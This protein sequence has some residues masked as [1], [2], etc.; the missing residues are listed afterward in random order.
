MSG[1]SSEPIAIV[2]IGCRFPGGCDT[3]SKLW[4]L[5]V[6][7]ED[8][9]Q[10]IP[11]DRFNVDR[12][13]H[14][15]G[16]HHGTTNVRRAYML[17]EDISQFDHQFFSITP[18]QAAAIDPQQ[19]LLLEVT[20]EAIESMGCTME[21]LHGSD[22]AVFVGM[23]NND[24]LVQQALD[25]DFSP[26]YNATGVAN[27]NAS[28]RV[29]YFFDWHGPSMTLDTACSSSLVAVYEAVQAIR[30]GTSKVAVAAGANLALIPLAYI[31]TS[32]LSM[33]S[34]TGKSR[35]WDA[36]ADGYA[37]GE[38]VA[39]V[40]LKK[41]SDAI[42]DG[43]NIQGVIREVGVNHDGR[44]AGLTMP[45]AT[46]QADLIRRVYRQAGLDP[47]DRNDRCQFFEAHGTGT[48]AGDPQEAEALSKAFFD[49]ETSAD[50]DMLFVGSI[51]TI[52][53]HTESTAGLAGLLRACLALK[54]KMI[55]PNLLFKQLNPAVAPFTSHLRIPTSAQPWPS[56]HGNDVVRRA[57]V[58]S[59]GFGGANAHVI[60]ESYDSTTESTT[61][62]TTESTTEYATD[63]TTDSSHSITFPSS[64][65][66]SADSDMLSPSVPSIPFVFSA[67][68]AGSLKANLRA[69]DA[70]LEQNIDTL[71]SA[72]LAHNLVT[73]KMGF[74]NRV[75]FSAGSLRDLK[76]QILHTLEP[77]DGSSS[78]IPTTRFSDKPCILGVFTG[79]GAQWATMGTKL[80]TSIPIASS[81][82][83]EL[84]LALS[85]LPEEDRPAWSLMQELLATNTSRLNQAE[86]SQPLCTAVQLV[87]V[88]LLRAARVKFSAVVGHSSGEIA[89][90]YAAGFIN[91]RDAMRISF[92]RGHYA[93][94]ASGASGEPGAM[95]AI[96]TSIE[97]AQELCQ[98]E[99]FVETLRVAAHNSPES[100]TLSGDSS[101]I[102]RARLVF[103]E[104]KKF[105]RPLKVD[106]AYHSQHMKPCELPY[107]RALRACGVEVL[108]P[109]VEA[110]LWYSSVKD[111]ELMGASS[112]ISAEYWV[113]N[114]IQPVLFSRAVA[115]A[116]ESSG[117]KFTF[118]LEVGPH[119]ALKTPTLDTIKAL[120][121]A[122]PGYSGT[123]YR[124]KHDVEAFKDMLG[125]L[126]TEAGSAAVDL[127]AFEKHVRGAHPSCFQP[128]P[129]LP[130][131]CWNHDRRLWCE[132]RSYK[133]ERSHELPYHD[134][135][136]RLTSDST[137]DQWRWRN[138][139]DVKQ[140]AW[141]SGHAL[142][143]QTVFPATGY[144]ALAMESA[145]QVAGSSSVQLVELLDLD[146]AK[147]IVIS[148]AAATELVIYM[149][150][151]AWSENQEVTAEFS[152]Y[153]AV[154]AKD[155]AGLTLNC[156]GSVRLTLE[157]NAPGRAAVPLPPREIHSVN[158]S[159]VD[160][161]RFYS[162]LREE[163]GYTYEEPF[164]NITKLSRRLGL[165]TGTIR[166]PEPESNT[167]QLVF[168]PAIADCALQGMFAT[169]SAPGDGPITSIMVP[170]S[171]RRI[172]LIPSLWRA[173]TESSV[174]F[175]C[176]LTKS[177]IVTGIAGDIDI[178]SSG[179]ENK[180]MQFEGLSFVPFAA[181]TKEEDRSLFQ[182]A[183]WCPNSPDGK[184][185]LGDREPTP[186]EKQKAL[187]AERAAFFYMCKL[188]QSVEPG[189]RASLP[190][191]R[192]A[193][194]ESTE[195]VV[196]CA[197]S[198][199][200]PYACE[201]LNDT[202]EEI[203]SMMDRQVLCKII[204]NGFTNSFQLAMVTM[205]TST[206]RVLL[207]STYR[208]QRSCPERS[209]FWN[210]W[211]RTTTSGV[212]IEKPPDLNL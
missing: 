23:M 106:T 20:Y 171:C 188:V 99:D 18:D 47:R 79:Q 119:P 180:M 159:E 5:L 196:D 85:T 103:E 21:Q 51:K 74:P 163:A 97:D 27:S 143:G 197:R 3:P 50:D 41:L 40:V 68:T 38:G 142:Q 104:E 121:S 191:Y 148:E 70:Y 12:F 25:V 13:Y 61:E 102:E 155:S 203:S 30:T 112:T 168:H 185:V 107:L 39:S 80:I 67:T 209:T 145:M 207:A 6:N 211:R 117:N 165:S 110:P 46:A 44:T 64:A 208:S 81:I 115:R 94:L 167:T 202:A 63:S 62:Y 71:C 54:H 176:H 60:L 199:A 31:T 151:I 133:H 198:G 77:K 126:W 184:L 91:K 200:H 109:P 34:P 144:I 132:A 95:I 129:E 2:G 120:G 92:Y 75:S 100:V 204:Q 49:E 127:L 123:L 84:D 26:K 125:A 45:S 108:Q 192:Q 195:R 111:G 72:S 179:Y 66:E 82:I 149:N 87:L 138:V 65:S 86:I 11:S 172:S 175:D 146:I 183:I 90:A 190:W 52:I 9:S 118:A 56:Q 161:E 160:V 182:E 128:I 35:M 24:Y 131:Y 10:E 152:V 181:A 19:R 113:D 16:S 136:G 98:L 130:S 194:L 212:T 29:S 174:D 201:W 193:L 169:Y 157:T 135:L 170:K 1:Q 37:R 137:A 134:L 53:G 93:K 122:I 78:N 88:D 36:D 43:D 28:S 139:L 101:A 42:R 76:A 33:L 116:W 147:A 156:R 154:A 83:E 59:F 153:S 166:I 173:Q 73:K 141:L 55:P 57:S 177:G 158:M 164:R 4:E 189:V 140:M 96:G 206:S 89:A 14:K 124:G 17:S 210:T 178:Y 69:F 15:I 186:E 48:Q 58:N 7:P 114:M 32:N 105:A 22:T 205:L 8:L 162:S 187:D 150:H